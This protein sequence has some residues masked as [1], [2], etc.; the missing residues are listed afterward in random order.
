MPLA[1]EKPKSRDLGKLLAEHTKAMIDFIPAIINIDANNNN[2][3]LLSLGLYALICLSMLFHTLESCFI[4][5][6]RLLLR[7]T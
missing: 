5:T 3:K 4:R 7:C 6:Y 2:R 1:A